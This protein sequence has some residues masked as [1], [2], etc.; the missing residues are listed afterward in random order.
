MFLGSREDVDDIAKAFEKVYE[1]R[2]AL[3]DWSLR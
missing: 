3:R 2:S 1:S